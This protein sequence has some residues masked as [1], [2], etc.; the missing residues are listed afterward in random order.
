[1]I[2]EDSENQ[3]PDGQVVSAASRSSADEGYLQLLVDAVNRQRSLSNQKEEL[4]DY[5]YKILDLRPKSSAMANRT[6]GYGYETSVGYPASHIKWCNIGNI[7]AVRSSWEKICKLFAVGANDEEKLV[8]WGSLVEDT[9][10][11]SFT[12]LILKVGLNMFRVV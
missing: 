9:K 11:L 6:Q 8:K 3:M 4:F 10:W 5:A 1:M 2:A 12:R 7:H